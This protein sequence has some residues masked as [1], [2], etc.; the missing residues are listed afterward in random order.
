MNVWLTCTNMILTSCDFTHSVFSLFLLNQKVNVGSLGINWNT[1]CV[2]NF[3]S[4]VCC[5]AGN[6]VTFSYLNQNLNT[7]SIIVLSIELSLIKS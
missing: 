5:V 2:I 3:Y 1:D 4:L 7:L 6:D